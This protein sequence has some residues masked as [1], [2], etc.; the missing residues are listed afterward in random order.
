MLIFQ[1]PEWLA[2]FSSSPCY[3]SHSYREALTSM[4]TFCGSSMFALSLGLRPHG[5]FS[6]ESRFITKIASHRPPWVRLKKS[7]ILPL[8]RPLSAWSVSGTLPEQHYRFT[9]I[10][11]AVASLAHRQNFSVAGVS[12][13]F[14]TAMPKVTGFGS[15]VSRTNCTR[16]PKL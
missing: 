15:G 8:F 14:R 7:T 12:R 10:S 5:I 6:C 13:P 4:T 9:R 11:T 2:Y 1:R 16:L 3:L